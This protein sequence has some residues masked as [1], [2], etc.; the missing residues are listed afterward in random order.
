MKQ[1][2]SI[3]EIYETYCTWVKGLGIKPASI[4]TYCETNYS[5]QRSQE[6]VLD[7]GC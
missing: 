6:Q 2:L 4:E 7:G 1:Q 3:I 5:D